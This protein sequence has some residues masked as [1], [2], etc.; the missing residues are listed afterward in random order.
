M[1]I[2]ASSVCKS[3]EYLTSALTQGG[4][5]G[6]LFRLTCS[7][8]LR[9]G[10]NTANITGVCGERSRCPGHTGF[11]PAH[12]VCASPCALLRLHV[13]LQRNSL[14]R[15]LGCVHFPGLSRSG[16]G[17]QVLHNGTD[18]AGPAFC[19]LP[20]SEQLRRPG[21]SRAHSPQVGRCVSSPPPSR[22][23]GFL[24]M[25]R[26]RCLRCAVCLLWGADLWL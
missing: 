5:R 11:A 18:S 3:L 23:L 6:H 10:R 14:K 24:S 8:E 21:A 17:S 2:L 12:G 26:E 20:G 7:V 16:S 19:A 13:A 25:Q 1:F 22:P 4:K 9:G 15:A